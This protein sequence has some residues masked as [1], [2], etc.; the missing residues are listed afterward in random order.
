[1]DA[2]YQHKYMGSSSNRLIRQGAGC[3]VVLIAIP[4]IY[5]GLYLLFRGPRPVNPQ[6]IAH[7]GGPVYQPEN[8]LPA[9]FQAIEDGADWIELDVQRTIDGVL[10]VIHDETVDRTTNGNGKVGELPFEEIRA[11][12][13]GNGAQVPTFEEVITLAKDAGVGILPEAKSPRLYPGIEAEITEF[14]SKRTT[15]RR[16]LSSPLTR[17]P[18]GRSCTSIRISGC[19]RLLDCGPW[20]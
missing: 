10:V 15:F 8:T 12:D 7:R 1:M 14:L 20:T 18:W 17:E 5:Y 11:L 19:A 3:L 6:L 9:F 2:Q 13:A 16:P 4:V